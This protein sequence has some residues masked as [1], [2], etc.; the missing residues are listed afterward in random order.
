[1]E[2][3]NTVGLLF[4]DNPHSIF[5]DNNRLQGIISA[6]NLIHKKYFHGQSSRK[7]MDFY[8]SIMDYFQDSKL[9]CIPINLIIIHF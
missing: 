1:M 5:K 7:K 4:L 2:S 9:H 6:K 8:G 3:Q